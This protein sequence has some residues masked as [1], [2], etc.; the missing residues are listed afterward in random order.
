MGLGHVVTHLSRINTADCF[1]FL[2]E[3]NY[4]LLAKHDI[5]AGKRA[6]RNV[7][8][9]LSRR[10]PVPERSF[11]LGRDMNIKGCAVMLFDWLVILLP[12]VAMF[13]KL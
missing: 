6:M 11:L 10:A 12:S 4:P 9:D 3:G 7:L 1:E 5:E 8:S 13:N 2:R